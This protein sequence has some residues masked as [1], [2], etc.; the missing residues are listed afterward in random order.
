MYLN[1]YRT[2]YE[3]SSI[4][5]VNHCRVLITH[6]LPTG[7]QPPTPLELRML[8]SYIATYYI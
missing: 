5:V 7:Q 2:T 1:E 8:T 6:Y 3:A 4:V